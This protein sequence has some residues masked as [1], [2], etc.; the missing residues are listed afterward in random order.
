MD[1]LLILSNEINALY[2]I[3]NSI[4]TSKYL[5]TESAKSFNEGSKIAYK[6][7]LKLIHELIMEE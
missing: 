4:D 1:K 6:N 7:V 5:T 2:E 3:T